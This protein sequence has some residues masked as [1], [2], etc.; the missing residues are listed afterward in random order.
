MEEFLPAPRALRLAEQR[1]MKPSL[2][3]QESIVGALNQLQ[4]SHQKRLQQGVC[5]IFTWIRCFTLYIAVMTKKQPD[6]IRLMVAHMHT[7]LRLYH[8]AP[9]QLAWLEYDIQYRM[10]T[11]ASEDRMWSSGDPWRY[12]SCLPGPSS[13]M[14]PFDLSEK[15]QVAN[16]LPIHRPTPLP[17]RTLSVGDAPSGGSKGK[18]PME[19]P[20]KGEP[21][22]RPQP[23]SRK[24]QQFAGCLIQPHWVA[25]MEKSALSS[26]GAQTV[27]PWMNMA[28]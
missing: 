2:S 6:M 22:W 16:P 1:N 27:V 9:E 28:D 3:L 19:G 26:T 5:E 15:E 24:S 18:R 12:L 21:S 25:H 11:A 8:K 10:E 17:I 4:A 7:V 14:D 13:A 20:I 23:R